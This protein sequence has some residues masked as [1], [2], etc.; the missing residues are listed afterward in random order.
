MSFLFSRPKSP[1][2]PPVPPPPVIPQVGPETGD[3]AAKLAKKRSGFAKTILTGELGSASG[4][5]TLLGD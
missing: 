1:A 3:F 2:M 4:G 5:K